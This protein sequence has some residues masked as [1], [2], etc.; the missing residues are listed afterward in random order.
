MKDKSRKLKRLGKLVRE[1]RGWS[2]RDARDVLTVSY[3][4][5]VYFQNANSPSHFL[6]AA[7]RYSTLC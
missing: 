6:Q 2:T 7:L 5:Y 3:G 1:R 4:A